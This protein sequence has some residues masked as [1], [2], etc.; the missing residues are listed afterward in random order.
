MDICAQKN[1]VRGHRGPLGGAVVIFPMV[2]GAMDG[3]CCP[4]SL[5]CRTFFFPAFLKL[6]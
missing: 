3:K 2:F 4:K 5:R 6:F 1:A